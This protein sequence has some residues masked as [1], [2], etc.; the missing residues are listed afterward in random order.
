MPLRVERLRERGRYQEDPHF[1]GARRGAI[2]RN[3]WECGI[4]EINS[5]LQL[6][7]EFNAFPVNH[8]VVVSRGINFFN[9]RFLT[10]L[11]FLVF[12]ANIC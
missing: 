7:L 5:A 3:H 11:T 8:D 4:S 6:I 9:D 1:A 12:L 2:L 10:F